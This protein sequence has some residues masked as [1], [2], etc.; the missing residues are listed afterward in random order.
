MI[1]FNDAILYDC[2]SVKNVSTIANLR[3]FY[4]IVLNP[5]FVPFVNFV[6]DTL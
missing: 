3:A 2:A 1:A 6:V 5:N 4:L